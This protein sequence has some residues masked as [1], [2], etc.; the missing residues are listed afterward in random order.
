MYEL[1]AENYSTIFPLDDKKAE[2]IIREADLYR[3]TE[4]SILDVGCA[5]GALAF[6]LARLG[7]RVTAVDPD[8]AM[9]AAAESVSEL[10]DNPHFYTGGMEDIK[11][12][13]RFDAVTCFGNTLPHLRDSNAVRNF[14]IDSAAVL[15]DSGCLI[16]QVINFEQINLDAEFRFPI[17]GT[18]FLTF[19]RSYTPRTDGRIDFNIEITDKSS[20]T[21]TSDSTPLLPVKKREL[22]ELLK[23]AGYRKIE[24]YS[25]Y[26]S[27]KTA[28]D[29]M[30]I[31]FTAGL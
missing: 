28:P 23:A 12:F 17:I 16:F 27:K 21:T 14:F 6:Q 26:N 1:I 20:K 31:I 25:D 24:L 18:D 5:D 15:K 13:G 3:K 29:D 22:T 4:A 8:E 2:F 30:S 9:I 11:D 10:T 19:K 7:Y